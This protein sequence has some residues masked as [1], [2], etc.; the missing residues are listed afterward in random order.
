MRSLASGCTFLW[1][2]IC[3][4]TAGARAETGIIV[5]SFD[6]NRPLDSNTLLEPLYSELIKKGWLGR[7]RLAEVIRQRVSADANTLT[8]TD[9]VAAQ[10]EVEDGVH[11]H[12][13]RD[14]VRRRRRDDRQVLDG[15]PQ[16]VPKPPATLTRSTRLLS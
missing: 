1:I 8:S 7:E 15:D 3:S 16:R 13:R 11:L 5:E 14:R 12:A 2:L 10:R 4:M 9:L 6:G